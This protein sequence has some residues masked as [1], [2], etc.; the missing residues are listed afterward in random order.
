MK[1]FFG[2]YLLY[3]IGEIILV[4]IGILIALQINTWNQARLDVRNEIVLLKNIANNL[5]SDIQQLQEISLNTKERLL[6]LDSIAYLLKT[7]E[8]I[9]QAKFFRY[10]FEFA[11]D[12]YFTCNSGFFDEA[13][14]SGK[15]SLIQNSQLLEKIFTYYHH[16]KENFQD[17]TTRKITDEIITPALIEII[18]LNKEGLTSSNP[19]LAE[20]V[21]IDAL[22]FKS[23][24]SNKKFWN[25]YSTKLGYNQYQISMWRNITTKA[26]RLKTEI[27]QELSNKK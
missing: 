23:L 22:D 9:D 12:S 20:V 6:N 21:E 13:V 2:K 16:V 4:V 25:M 24:R 1:G 5:E 26:E 15:M 19:L 18:Y 17:E 8:S 11:V 7:P 14:S 27:L 10:A 3:A